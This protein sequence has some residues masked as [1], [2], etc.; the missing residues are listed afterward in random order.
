MTGGDELSMRALQLAQLPAGVPILP[1]LEVA[2]GYVGGA[3][4]H[5]AGGDWFYVL[6]RWGGVVFVGDVVGGGVAACLA[7]GRLRAVLAEV[8]GPDTD[9]R[10]TDAFGT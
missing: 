3:D 10:T 4:E 5:T 9:A 2:T 1:T 7:M 6:P 8:R